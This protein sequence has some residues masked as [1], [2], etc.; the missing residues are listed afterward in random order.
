[1]AAVLVCKIVLHTDLGIEQCCLFYGS[2]EMRLGETLGELTL[3]LSP[4][5]KS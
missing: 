4:N 5:P 1:M 2:D 3:T